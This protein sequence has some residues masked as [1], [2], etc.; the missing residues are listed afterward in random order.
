MKIKLDMRVDVYKLTDNFENE[1]DLTISNGKVITTSVGLKN[2]AVGKSLQYIQEM[3]MDDTFN[4][5]Y[6]LIKL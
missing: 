4:N 3:V 6:K 2:W 1:L 5:G